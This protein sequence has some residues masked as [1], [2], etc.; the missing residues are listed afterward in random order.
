MQLVQRADAAAAWERLAPQEPCA[1]GDAGIGAAPWCKLELEGAAQPGSCAGLG[2][3]DWSLVR[4]VPT[5]LANKEPEAPAPATLSGAVTSAASS[6]AELERENRKLKR[7]VAAMRKA[8]ADVSTKEAKGVSLL[9]AVAN[10]RLA[11]LQQED[12]SPRYGG[13]ESREGMVWSL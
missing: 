3:K 11:L 12:C 7:E 8:I 5:P 9:K 2:A 10:S 6:A 13:R 4:K 1:Y